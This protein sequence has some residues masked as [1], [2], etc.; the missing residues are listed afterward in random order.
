MISDS[1][2]SNLRVH[3]MLEKAAIA[4]M[5][6][7]AELQYYSTGT[8]IHADPLF[9]GWPGAFPWQGPVLS[10]A[11]RGTPLRGV[12]CVSPVENEHRM[13]CKTGCEL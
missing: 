9:Q 5:Q 1:S 6:C 10:L 12:C 4:L 13:S 7:R 11:R 8:I 3:L 2:I